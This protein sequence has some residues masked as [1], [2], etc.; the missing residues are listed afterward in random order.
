MVSWRERYC[1]FSTWPF[2]CLPWWITLFPTFYTSLHLFS[3]TWHVYLARKSKQ[4]PLCWVQDVL[5]GNRSVLEVCIDALDLSMAPL[6][7]YR[8]RC[9]VGLSSSIWL[10]YRPW[11]THDFHPDNDLLSNVRIGVDY[12]EGDQVYSFWCFKVYLGTENIH[13]S[14]WW[15]QVPDPGGSGLWEDIIREK[16]FLSPRKH[17]IS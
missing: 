6:L 11:D 14:S 16:E 9:F 8:L 1:A 5:F 17:W 2:A 3:F 13:L 10:S 12:V 15:P 7:K 4:G